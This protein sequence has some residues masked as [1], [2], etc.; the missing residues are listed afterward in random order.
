MKTEDRK[1]L[2]K[3]TRKEGGYEDDVFRV[4]RKEIDNF[5]LENEK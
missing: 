3:K 1:K 4:S 5:E 2:G